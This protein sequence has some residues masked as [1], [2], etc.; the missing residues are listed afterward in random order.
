MHV[1]NL[2]ADGLQQ[3]TTTSGSTLVSQEQNCWHRT[4]TLNRRLNVDLADKFGFL[5]QQTDGRVKTLCQ[6]HGFLEPNCLLS[7]FHAGGGFVMVWGMFF[8]T[9]WPC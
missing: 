6:Q 2:E 9:L 5:L 7:T 8:G 4:P 3:Q 1:S